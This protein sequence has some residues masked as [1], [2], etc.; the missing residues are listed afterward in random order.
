MVGNHHFIQ[1]Y[2]V[3][4]NNGHLIMKIREHPS[5]RYNVHTHLISVLFSIDL[6]VLFSTTLIM[7]SKSSFLTFS[8]LLIGFP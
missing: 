8:I 4:K 1:Y 2:L 5:I 7:F 3:A 6:F